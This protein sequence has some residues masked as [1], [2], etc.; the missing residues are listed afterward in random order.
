VAG[1]VG[2]RDNPKTDSSAGAGTC[3]PSG[4]PVRLADL[5]RAAVPVDQ[6][7]GRWAS[8]LADRGHGFL[9]VD[10]IRKRIEGLSAHNTL[11]PLLRVLLHETREGVAGLR[12]RARENRARRPSGVSA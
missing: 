4:A 7:A 1:V 12:A 5:I 2:Y 3:R 11:R 6:R 8:A 10:E 9:G